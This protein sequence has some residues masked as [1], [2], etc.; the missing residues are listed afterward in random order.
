[1]AIT[2][3]RGNTVG[4][5]DPPIATNPNPDLAIKA[6]VRAATTGS[7]ISL[8]GLQTID[9]VTLASG[10]RVLVKD[11]A[12]QTTNG[13][14]NAQTGN[15][16]RS[17]DA[18]NNSQWAQGLIV[19]ATQGTVNANAAFAVTTANPIILGTS[20][21]TFSAYSTA[22]FA[23][24][25]G[26]ATITAAGLLTL[27]AVPP[28][29]AY[30]ERLKADRT[31]FIRTPPTTVTLTLGSPGLVNWTSHGLAANAAVVFNTTGSLPTGLTVGTI[32]YVV[33]SSITA[34]GFE[35]SAAPNGAAINFT[36]GQS[37]TQS[38]QTGSD[39]NSGLTNTASGA[40][41]TIQRYVA[42]VNQSLDL[43]GGNSVF[44]QLA[45]GQYNENV[46]LLSYVGRG[47]QGHTTPSIQGDAAA[48]TAV[49]VNATLFGFSATESE[50]LEWVI[51]NLQIN[52]AA[53]SGINC[54]VGGWIALDGV[55]FGACT[56]AVIASGGVIEFVS[57]CTW[58]GNQ[59]ACGIQTSSQSKILDSG[60]AHIISGN[61]SWGFS[62]IYLTNMSHGDFTGTTFTGASTGTRWLID[63]SSFVDS[64]GVPFD[65][66]FPGNANG[67]YTPIEVRRGGTAANTASGTALDNITGF[68]ATGLLRRTGAG[69]YAFDLPS[70]TAFKVTGVNFNSANTDNP[71]AITLP[72]GAIGYAE[73]RMTIG[74]A[75]A[76]L[77]LSTIGLFG[78]AGGGSAVIADNPVTVTTG[79][80]NT[81]N[82]MQA[83]A[84]SANT[85]WNYTTLYV[86][87]GT[88]EGS[89]ATGDVSLELT[90][91]Y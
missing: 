27:A 54:D 47:S 51:K 3:I 4:A 75:S 22:A 52:C 26:D 35:V 90:W 60:N 65:T 79:A 82:N 28:S 17:V 56:N 45:H 46:A 91:V 78:A 42:I 33:G 7:N 12:D 34:N 87:I 71:V 30:R 29:G 36:V 1:M 44:G 19:L 5:T 59:V 48:K 66:L 76:S 39:T 8:S 57:P 55:T 18:Q 68:S 85:M 77:S 6:P 15:W 67:S 88:A 58:A 64:G 10:D 37:G 14:Y 43:N 31:Y 23:T 49:V 40:L 74:N 24:V 83:L 61:P 86:R 72:P 70:R 25:S 73:T 53:G 21:I 20:A 41:L 38:A 63:A 13:I 9:G 50:G 69:T 89:A 80:P 62:F 84:G 32:Y 81:G 2:D 16:Q 11:Q